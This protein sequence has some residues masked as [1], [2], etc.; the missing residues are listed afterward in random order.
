MALY[1]PSCSLGSVTSCIRCPPLGKEEFIQYS[2]WDQAIQRSFEASF[3]VSGEAGDPLETRPDLVH[4][5]HIYKDSFGAS[6]AWCDYQLRPNFT[7]AMVVVRRQTDRLQ[8]YGLHTDRLKTD[9]LK[10]DRVETER[11]VTDRRVTHRQ[12]DMLCCD[13]PSCVCIGCPVL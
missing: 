2:W 10:T 13:R 4:K 3:W 8:T 9:R 6:S 7:I 1:T 11:H 12:T 5:Q